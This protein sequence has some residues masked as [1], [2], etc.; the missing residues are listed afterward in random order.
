VAWD[1]T[2][3]KLTKTING[4]SSD[5]VSADTIKA[6]LSLD[7]G[8]VGLGSVTNDAQVKRSEM[9][10]ANGVATLDGEGK[11]PSSQ[12]PGYV[13]DVEEYATQSAFP[14]T[15]ETGKI[16][17]DKA[18]NKTYRWGGTTYVEIS[19]SDITGIKVG[20][21]GTTITPSGG[22]IT[23]PAY[24]TGAQ[25]NTVI[26]VAGKTGAVT[27]DKSDV[28]LG[29]VGNFKAVSTAASQGLTATEKSNA[30]TNIGAGTSSFSGSYNDLSNKP[31]IPTK[32]SDLTND[33][34]FTAVTKA[35]VTGWG[36]VEAT[37][38]TDAEIDE[39]WNAVA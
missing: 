3:K 19:S 9:G 14:A 1:G 2:N 28:G 6:A 27:L 13:D 25:V 29:N 7:K 20:S 15:G 30:R 36:F 5:V 33:S 22:V 18:T 37:A 10:V 4:T 24:E 21:S 8:D 34:G 12:L 23:I 16:Y 26:S 38:L 32:V 39:L 17:V 35:T 11:V 31:T